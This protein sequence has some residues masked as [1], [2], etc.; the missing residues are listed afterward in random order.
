[1]AA[2]VRIERRGKRD[3]AQQVVITANLNRG[4]TGSIQ[5]IGA[6]AGC[7]CELDS[8]SLYRSGGGRFSRARF[9]GG[10]IGVGHELEEGSVDY[11]D[12]ARL[13]RCASR[14]FRGEKAK[15]EA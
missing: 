9:A 5:R 8:A 13:L 1:M 6:I 3:G 14:R 4:S 10:A 11:A 7:C 2:T 12:R 15:P